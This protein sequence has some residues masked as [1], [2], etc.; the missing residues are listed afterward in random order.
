MVEGGLEVVQFEPTRLMSPYLLAL[1]AGTLRDYGGAGGAGVR[2]L[3]QSGPQ[4]QF[5]FY[6][7]PGLEWQLA[8]ADEVGAFEHVVCWGGTDGAERWIW[9]AA[10]GGGELMLHHT[11][12]RANRSSFN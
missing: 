8:K 9:M 7:V 10:E 5:R 12:S 11:A 6:S 3:R 1:A 2:R 4:P